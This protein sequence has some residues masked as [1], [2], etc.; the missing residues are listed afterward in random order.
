MDK[1]I[2]GKNRHRQGEGICRNLLYQSEPSFFLELGLL[3]YLSP[4]VSLRG[5]N[6]G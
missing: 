5:R 1:D 2:K 3:P 6:L 4:E